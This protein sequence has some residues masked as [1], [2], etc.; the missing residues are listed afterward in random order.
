M[1]EYGRESFAHQVDIGDLAG[2]ID[3][4]DEG[5][6]IPRRSTW[7]RLLDRLNPVRA[8]IDS[9]TIYVPLPVLQNMLKMDRAERVDPGAP[10]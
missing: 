7:T 4:Q 3:Q 2:G 6:S 5:A 9:Q 10:V 1:L 8:E